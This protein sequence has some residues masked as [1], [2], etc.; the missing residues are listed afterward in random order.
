MLCF[1]RFESSLNHSGRVKS[2]RP[3][4]T[5]LRRFHLLRASIVILALSVATAASAQITTYGYQG[6]DFNEFSTPPYT[7][8]THISGSFQVA[9][10]LPP[11]QP[12][13]DISQQLLDFSF[14]D[15]VNT[16]KLSDSQICRFQIGTNAAG[17]ISEFSIWLRR[18]GTPP[19]EM[20]H[21]LETTH[22]P[23]FFDSADLVALLG[24][25]GPHG[26]VP[27]S[28]DS[29]REVSAAV[30]SSAILHW[31]INGR[32]TGPIPVIPATSLHSLLLLTG[33]LMLL[34]IP[35]MRRQV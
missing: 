18:D 4:D 24:P 8:A 28:R 6:P 2:F 35:A 30:F 32:P 25:L 27:A 22:T 21:E 16:R 14:N 1:K 26:C 10:P 12:L 11:N 34:A 33:L 29:Y 9:T 19:D 3:G 7:G 15:G 13:T 20:E 31:S 5:E 17:E 23:S